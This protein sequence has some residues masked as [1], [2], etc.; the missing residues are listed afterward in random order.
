MIADD[1]HIRQL[2]YS[3]REDLTAAEDGIT[4]QQRDWSGE[5]RVA[6]RFDVPGFQGCKVIFAWADLRPPVEGYSL[7]VAKPVDDRDGSTV[8]SPG[9]VADID[10]DA[11]QALEVTGNLVQS[12]RQ[13]PLFDTFQLED[14]NV[15]ECPGPAIMKH[16][17]LRLCRPPETIGDKRVLGRLEELLYLPSGE[18]LPESGLGLRVEVPFLPVHLRFGRQL[19]VPVIQRIEHPA[20]DI[21]EL[22]ITGLSRDFGPI[23]VILIFPVDI[24]QLEKWIPV[25]KG[26]PQLFEIL[27]RVANDH[28]SVELSSAAPPSLISSGISN[29]NAFDAQSRRAMRPVFCLSPCGRWHR[30]FSNTKNACDGL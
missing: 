11:V 8:V 6:L 30:K 29:P 22:I 15:A 20:E 14:P 3:Q 28:G 12:G 25:V 10:D 2:P 17:G 23:G 5:L 13:S 9:V 4:G 27:F 21:E 1:R 18:L 19:H 26:L 7:A 24:P 16:P